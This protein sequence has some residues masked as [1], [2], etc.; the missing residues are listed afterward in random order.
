M[1]GAINPPELAGIVDFAERP[2]AEDWSLRAAL[3]R[4]AQPEP[5]R[6]SDILEVVRR[7]EF[8]LA[9]QNKTLERDGPAL[10]EALDGDDDAPLVGLLRTAREL[11]SLGDVLVKW[12]ID[13]RKPRP[14]K[15]VDAAV[16]SVAAQ[17]DE[18]GVPRE[19]RPPGPRNRG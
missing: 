16:H 17:L 1:P 2:R 12:A 9:K 19:E 3:V 4:Y 13:Y 18:M 11:D 15:L 6:A 14:D 8:A 10:L 7:V 5:Q